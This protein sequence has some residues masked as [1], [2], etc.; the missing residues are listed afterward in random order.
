[1]SL[2]STDERQARVITNEWQYD[3][4]GAKRVLAQMSVDNSIKHR[5]MWQK[6]QV[7]NIG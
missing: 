5:F 3:R 6:A 1:M 2:I 7:N 4:L